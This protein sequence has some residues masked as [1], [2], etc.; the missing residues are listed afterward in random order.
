[1]AASKPYEPL[2]F[3]LGDVVKLKKPH[4]CG[5]YDWT[6]TRLGADIGLKCRG[7]ERRVLLTRREA[8]RRFRGWVSKAATTE[9]DAAATVA[10]APA[11]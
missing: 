11:P 7:C 4:P 5:S 3:A 1:M 2:P 6:V 10:V 9:P 8:E